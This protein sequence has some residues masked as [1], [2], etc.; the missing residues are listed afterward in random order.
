MGF[1]SRLFGDADAKSASTLELFREIYG[2]RE[3][4]S[5]VS[6]NW[7]TAIEVAT[8]L[9]CVRV[10]A[11][12]VAQVPWRV[13]QDQGRSKRPAVNHYLY[14]VIY[15]RPNKWQSSFALRET[16]MYHLL[17]TGN[18]FVWKGMVGSKRE[19]RELKPIE[20]HRVTVQMTDDVLT[21]RV[22]ADNGQAAVFP[23]DQIWHLRGPSWNTWIGLDAT[24]LARD[25]IGLSIAT[26]TAQAELHKNGA[27]VGGLLSVD[28]NLSKE[29]FD[30]LSAWLDKHAIGG[31]R[32][33]KP[34]ILDHGAKFSPFQMTGVDA[35]HLETRKHQIEEICRAYGVMPIMVG[36]A[37]K[38]ATYASAEQMFLA[39]VVY[40]LLPWYERIE[41][42]ADNELLSETDRADGY[43][44]KFSPN[45]LLR[46]AAKDRAEFYSKALGGPGARGYMTPNEVRSLEELDPIDGGDTIPEPMPAGPS[47]PKPTG[48]ENDGSN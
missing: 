38:T 32:S 8:V 18:A 29:Q 33:Q 47:E 40:T 13:Y 26:E 11:N 45:G 4:R 5:G 6:V 30:F 12:G 1:W 20:P 37:D 31:E 25:A 24:K 44:T 22:Q 23:A 14:P 39:H 43:Y 36:H 15:R 27:R 21:Y 10:I 42:S 7:Q 19:I 17:L 35:Q 46:G 28:G 41:Q 34:L 48:D 2:G 3:A 9:A 16:V